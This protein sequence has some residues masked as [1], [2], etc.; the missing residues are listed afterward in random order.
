MNTPDQNKKDQ[1]EKDFPGYPSYPA[2][3]DITNQDDK[4]DF[5]TL[6]APDR[7]S[8]TGEATEQ[9]G[10]EVP[11]ALNADEAIDPDT[12]VTPDDIEM[13]T[14]ADQHRDIDDPEIEASKLDETDEDGDPLNEITGTYGQTGADLDVPGSEGD[15]GNENIG[16]EDEEN[17]YYSLGGD[18]H[19]NLEEDNDI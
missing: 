2:S 4:T 15:D 3:D 10:E 17:N 8:A 9:R 7:N 19:E 6:H 16:E 13:L 12:D 18:N 1:Q 11:R 5:G 14:A